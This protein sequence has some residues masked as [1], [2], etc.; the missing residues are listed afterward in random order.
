MQIC[1]PV[2]SLRLRLS[3]LALVVLACTLALPA[4]ALAED[5][6]IDST[7]DQ[8]DAELEMNG[9]QT[10][11]GKCTLRAAIEESN[12]S[13]GFADEITF[14]ATVFQGQNADTISPGGPLPE[15]IDGVTI[16]GESAGPCTTAAGV[17]GPCVGIDGVGL[18]VEADSVAIEG[19]SLTNAIAGIRVFGG[20]AGFAALDNWV[21]IKLNGSAG[22]NSTGVSVNSNGLVSGAEE[23]LIAAN[24]I[25]AGN[26]LGSGFGIV[27]RGFG[28][29]IASNQIFAALAGITTTGSGSQG[30][31]IEGNL[32]EASEIAGIQV[33]N[34]D[35]ELFGNEITESGA[36]GVL[37]KEDFLEPPTG[38][39]IGGNAP[40]DENV[41][42]G[43]R[44]DAIAIAGAEATVN[45]VARNRGSGNGG[46]FIDLGADGEG[47]PANGPNGGIQPPQILAVTQTTTSGAGAEAGARI[48]VFR[49]A[50][51]E[52]GE[53]ESFL[54]E[55]IADGT[56][57]WKVGYAAIAG[58]TI[59]AATQTNVAGATSELTMGAM[60]AAPGGRGDGGSGSN[61]PPCLTSGCGPATDSPKPIP[62]TTIVKSPK[63]K[64]KSRIARFKFNSDQSGS[65]FQC[66]LDGKRFGKCTSPRK[67]EDLKPGKH[68]FE[69][70]AIGSSGEVDPTPARRVFTV[71]A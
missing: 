38:N 36:A 19:L 9:C 58:G 55:T 33:E 52:A 7:G 15:I 8:A 63:Q 24:Q 29:T 68:R 49:K 12:S 18:E 59:V 53:L 32:I 44:D 41:I 10:S 4:S 71:L 61:D 70:R 54:A 57:N 28:A 20:S 14:D 2:P 66:R 65:S 43:T 56:G 21:G 11:G 3:I 40:G 31:L 23:A 16:D 34:D 26:E 37:I 45:E 27:Q 5:F 25:Q 51:P 1:S 42:S 48:R 50:G 39:V 35:N 17:E 46:L 60:P 30:N 64:S 62:Q 13:V 69:V 47:N 22:V 67:Y 6:V